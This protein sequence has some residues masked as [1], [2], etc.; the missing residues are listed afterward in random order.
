MCYI[1]ESAIEQWNDN[2]VDYRC[3]RCKKEVESVDTIRFCEA[4]DD[5]DSPEKEI[6]VCENCKNDIYHDK[7]LVVF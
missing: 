1:T 2:V 6:E 5:E 4:S 7:K 3:D